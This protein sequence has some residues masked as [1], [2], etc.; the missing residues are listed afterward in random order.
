[1]SEVPKT[2]R[3]KEVGPREG[4]AVQHGVG[5]GAMDAGGETEEGL[6]GG[7]GSPPAVEAGGELVEVGREAIVA[8]AVVGT[9]EPGLELPELASPFG[10]P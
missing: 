6:E 5:R 8:D 9:A 7:H 4:N 10:V 3:I 1:M 2:V